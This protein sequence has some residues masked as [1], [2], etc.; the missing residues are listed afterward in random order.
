MTTQAVFE[1]PSGVLAGVSTGK[2]IVDCATLTPER[3][4]KEA[5][6]VK[7]RG[8][9]FLEAPVSGSKGPAEMGQV[10]QPYPILC[11]LLI[12]VTELGYSYSI[13]VVRHPQ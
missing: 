11:F 7:E 6:M 8:G 3:M 1:C 9:Q 4:L 2:L 13:N 12:N 10:V 5:K